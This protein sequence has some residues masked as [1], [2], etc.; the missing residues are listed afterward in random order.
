M[1]SICL[2]QIR[3]EEWIHASTLQWF[4][5]FFLKAD[6]S[7]KN[8]IATSILSEPLASPKMMIHD[9]CRSSSLV[10]VCFSH[11]DLCL[12]VQQHCYLARWGQGEGSWYLQHGSIGDVEPTLAL[13][14]AQQFVHWW[15]ER[16]CVVV[17]QEFGCFGV[18]FGARCAELRMAAA[19][20]SPRWLP[21]PLEQPASNPRADLR[22]TPCA[23]QQRRARQVFEF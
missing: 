15:W 8:I 18:R 4:I 11:G 23:R 10:Q 2:L 14:L 5:Y 1:A 6:I 19:P 7:F 16:R 20:C 13:L 21:Y 3:L 9:V 17:S 12:C 22:V